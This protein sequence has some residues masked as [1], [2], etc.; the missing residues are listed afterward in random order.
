MYA[1]VDFERRFRILRGV[2]NNFC[3][4]IIGLEP[5]IKHRN[6]NGSPTI[7]PIYQLIAALHVLTDGTSADNGD[8]RDRMSETVI[9]D[10]R[11]VFC[12]YGAFSNHL[13]FFYIVILLTR[14][15]RS[16]LLFYSK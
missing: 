15:N 14:Q 1:E 8:E 12:F 2:F 13:L 6:K 9:N 3:N 5:F 11:K 10:A 16:E 7:H 4:K